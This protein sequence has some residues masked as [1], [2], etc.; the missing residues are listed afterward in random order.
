MDSF[1]EGSVPYDLARHPYFRSWTDPRT[2]VESFILQKRLAP[3]QRALYFANPSISGD[4]KW[5]WFNSI[6]PPSRGGILS[7][8]RLDPEAPD[9]RQFP[10]A[11]EASGQPYVLPDGSG[12]WL[13]IGPTLYHVDMEG[14]CHAICRVP[15]DIIGGMHFWG[16]YSTAMPSCDG[17]HILANLRIGGRWLMAVFQKVGA[18]WQF[19]PLAWKHE[20]FMHGTFSPVH[21][22]LFMICHNHHLDPISGLKNE[23]HV[24]IWLMD[25]H[26]KMFEPLCGDLWWNHNAMGCHEWWAPDGTIQ[27]CDYADGVHE[28]DLPTRTR[29]VIWPHPMC[30]GQCDSEKRFH[31]GDENPYHRD[32]ARPCHVWLFDRRTGN[33]VAIVHD[34][35]LP[36]TIAVADA[37]SYHFDPHP[38]FSRDNKYVVYTTTV[39]DR[40]DVAL[41][42]VAAAVARMK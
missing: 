30:H 38:H 29:R 16:W 19:K 9:M 8:V 18:E 25:T 11:T 39:L 15:P 13:P 22:D 28:C 4:G 20:C 34:M 1:K 3:H 40:L 27:W 17:R 31:V 41:T 6:Y 26:G 24:R 23:M 33:E 36:A 2:G 37:R 12:L 21:P 5:L 14:R 35:P 42:P 7:A 32:T 10:C